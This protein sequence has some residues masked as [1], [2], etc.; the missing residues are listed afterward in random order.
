MTEQAQLK[1]GLIKPAQ[2]VVS[3]PLPMAASEVRGALSS[4]FVTLDSN[5]NGVYSVVGS[6]TIFGHVD[7]PAETASATA[8][9]TVYGCIIDPTAVFRVPISAGTY[10]HATYRGKVCDPAVSSNVQG[11]ALDV[12]TNA[13]LIIVDGDVSGDNAWVDVMINQ[14]ERIRT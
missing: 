5:G 8:G 11:A 6:A 4:G 12:T 1:F 3:V 2:D 7:S 14:E 9:A 10:A 13:L